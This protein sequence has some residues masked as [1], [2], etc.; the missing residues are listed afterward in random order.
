VEWPLGDRERALGDPPLNKGPVL[1]VLVVWSTALYLVPLAVG[2]GVG[3]VPLRLISSGIMFDQTAVSFAG[4]MCIAWS[5][6]AAGLGFAAL[7]GK[8]APTPFA[9]A[10]G[11]LG[12]TLAATLLLAGGVLGVGPGSTLLLGTEMRW[13]WK[14]SVGIV[15][16]AV[17]L[18]APMLLRARAEDHQLDFAAIKKGILLTGLLVAA[19]L[20]A[21]GPGPLLGRGITG[22]G[23]W[24]GSLVWVLAL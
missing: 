1:A 21:F 16:L 5:P 18:T 22:G 8:L 23:S 19:L 11:I 24:L 10:A 14:L 12:A 15:G 2:V 3:A 7:G 9:I 17:G 20:L 4:F 6:V 13:L